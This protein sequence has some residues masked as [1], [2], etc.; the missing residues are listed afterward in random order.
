MTW[1]D[2]QHG[3]MRRIPDV[4]DAWYDSGSMPVAQWHYPFENR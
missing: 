4:A 2:P 1:E 3:T